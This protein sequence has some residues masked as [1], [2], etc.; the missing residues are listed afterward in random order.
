MIGVRKILRVFFC[1]EDPAADDTILGYY[2]MPNSLR[3]GGGAMR[4]KR[5]GQM[6]ENCVQF[7]FEEISI[8]E[9]NVVV[10]Q[11]HSQCFQPLKACF[12]KR[13]ATFKL[14]ED[15]RCASLYQMRYK[16]AT[17]TWREP[18]VVDS[19]HPA[20]PHGFYNFFLPTFRE[21]LAPLIR[22]RLRW[23]S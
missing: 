16:I 21:V 1:E 13:G 2:A 18:F 3:C 14:I 20:H 17:S 6:F 8:L 4:W 10:T 11:S 23:T 5:P 22:E 19:P 7:L 15:H 12:E 9:P